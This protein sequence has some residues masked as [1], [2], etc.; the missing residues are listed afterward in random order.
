[1]RGCA[2]IELLQ[3]ADRPAAAQ[4]R[5]GAAAVGSAL[6]PG[7]IPVRRADVAVHRAG[8]PAGVRLAEVHLRRLAARRSAALRSAAIQPRRALARAE[9]AESQARVRTALF[10]L[11]QEVNDAFFAAA[12]LQE[13]RGALD[14]DD[15]PT[16]RRACARQ[17]ACAKARRCRRDAAAIEATLLQ[18]RQQDRRAAREPRARALARLA[19]LTGRPIRCRRR[20]D[21]ARPRATR[22]AAR[23]ALTSS[24]RGPSTSSSR[25]RDRVAAQQDGDEAQR[26][27]A[28]VGIRPRGYGRPGSTSSATGPKPTRWP[29]SSSSGRHG[30]GARRIAKGGVALQQQ[31]V[32]R[33]RSGVHQ[34]PPPRDRGR[35]R[36]DRSSRA[37]A[38]DRRAD[39]R[40]C[41]RASI[42]PRGA[43]AGRR[44]H[45][46]GVSRSRHRT[47][48][49]AV[50]RRP[51]TGSSWRRRG[52][53]VLTTLGLE[54]R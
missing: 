24:A 7:A 45:R 11:R 23:D 48:P 38:R 3:R 53:R 21:V 19:T 5:R 32:V 15:R 43:L 22:G 40:R 44:D 50:R 47:A 42:G 8:R 26:T 54:V 29:A 51:R 10:A 12:L 28:G 31:I 35:P 52:A 46:V 39:R 6:G 20:L 30:T 14:G 25:A 18:R 36:D 34:E 4:H 13:Q 37:L 17:P 9:L 49:R 33:R 2:E 1:M 41:V 16:S 27:A